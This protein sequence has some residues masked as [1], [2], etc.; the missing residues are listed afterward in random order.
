MKMAVFWIVVPCSL[1]EVYRRFGGTCCLYYQGDDE[2][3]YMALEPR[4]QP[5]SDLPPREPQILQRH[6]NW[7][8][9]LRHDNDNEWMNEWT[10]EPSVWKWV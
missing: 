8:K 2:G 1:V 7:T 6:D 5:S 3:S 10:I 9:Y 4:R